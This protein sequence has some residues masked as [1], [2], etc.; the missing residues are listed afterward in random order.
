[1]GDLDAADEAFAMAHQRGN[2]AQPGLAFCSSHAGSSWRRV[3]R[4]EERWRNSRWPSQEPGCSRRRSRSRS[5]PTMRQRRVQRPR[6]SAR[7]PR[8]TTRPSEASAH[9]ALGSVLTFEGDAGGAIK[10]LRQAIR[11]WTE[12]DL[13]FETA[14]ARRCLANAHR[15]DGDEASALLELR[16][17]RDPRPP[18]RRTRGTALPRSDRVRRGNPGAAGRANVHVHGYRRIDGSAR[19]DRRRGGKA[20]CAGTTRP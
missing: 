20:S 5:R 1:M 6:S 19:D 18:R 2:D 7:S 10:E 12:A 9:Q 15:L 16:A 11:L 4:S 17:A 3:R 13:P 14:W 8:A